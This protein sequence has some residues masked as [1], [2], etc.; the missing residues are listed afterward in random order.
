MDKVG[1]V[2]CVY[3]FQLW[4]MKETTCIAE[5]AKET[6]SEA[7][8]VPPHVRGQY[9]KFK[10]MHEGHRSVRLAHEGLRKHT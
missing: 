4:L 6:V 8:Q 3:R 2:G 5:D 9:E 10:A 1:V 7:L